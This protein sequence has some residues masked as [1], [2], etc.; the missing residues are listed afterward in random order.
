[1]TVYFI[2][3][4]PGDPELIT[5]KGARL[6][7]EAQLVLYA[8][9]L[10]NK[11]I[12][13]HASSSATLVDSAGLD[14]EEM[15]AMMVAAVRDGQRVVRLHTGDPALYG[16]IQEQMDALR[17]QGIDSVMVPGVSSYAAAAAAVGRELTMPEVSQ[18]VVITRLAGRTPVPE[19]ESLGSL[20]AHRA[21]MCIFLS[22]GMMERVA[23]ELMAAYPAETP[24][25]V[26]EKA[27]WPEERV[28]RGTL[29]TIAEKVKE[30]GVTKTAMILVGD[31]LRADAMQASRLYAADFSHEYRD[32]K[33]L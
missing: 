20:A 8:G 6:L 24:V 2:G 5:V 31:F 13:V 30:A 14:L 26:V 23:G 17:L 27:S 11:D 33:R 19:K 4:G 29:S 18:T 22:V 32:G 7:A 10:V 21:S 3:A 9:S 15:V 12:L 16:A 25:A 28:I 1:M